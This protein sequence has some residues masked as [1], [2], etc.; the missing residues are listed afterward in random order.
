MN[1][2]KQEGIR[3]YPRRRHHSAFPL[4]EPQR[5]S[6]SAWRTGRIWGWGRS[7]I[8]AV[9]GRLL[10]D[11]QGCRATMQLIWCRMASDWPPRLHSKK[12]HLEHLWFEFISSESTRFHF[13]HELFVPCLCLVYVRCSSGSSES[14]EF[15]N[16]W[17]LCFQA[18]SSLQVAPCTDSALLFFVLLSLLF[19]WEA[20]L[21]RPCF[22]WNFDI[23]LLKHRKMGGIMCGLGPAGLCT[24]VP[25]CCG[26]SLVPLN[27]SRKS[28]TSSYVDLGDPERCLQH[29]RYRWQLRDRDCIICFEFWKLPSTETIQ[30]WRIASL[31]FHCLP[32]S[33]P[34]AVKRWLHPV[35]LRPSAIEFILEY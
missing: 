18:W 25:C 10:K 26:I 4:T 35:T 13:C 32:W 7:F 17:L 34:K 22:E 15:R 6:S 28:G 31:E 5:P 3:R 11:P 19:Q 33:E 8:S 2:A 23:I 24:C 14:H 27:K 1:Y 16:I 29:S 9:S 20:T 21:L 30:W 12:S